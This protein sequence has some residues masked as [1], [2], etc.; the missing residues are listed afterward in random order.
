MFMKKLVELSCNYHHGMPMIQFKTIVVKI[1]DIMKSHCQTTTTYKLSCGQLL[2]KYRECKNIHKLETI[3]KE[4][5]GPKAG[6]VK[7]QTPIERL[8]LTRKL[9]E[10]GYPLKT[11]Y[12]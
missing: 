5:Y 6:Q 10:N 9:E 4:Q 8:V 7:P 12:G 2:K 1:E 11:V 3:C